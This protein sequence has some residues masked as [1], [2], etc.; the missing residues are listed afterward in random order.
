MPLLPNRR[1]HGRLA[2]ILA[3]C[4][5]LSGCSTLTDLTT[6][7]PKLP[8]LAS[9]TSPSPRPDAS[10][11]PTVKALRKPGGLDR[12]S[13]ER[14]FAAAGVQLV[15]DYWTTDDAS[16]WGPASQG[17]VQL[18][19]QVRGVKDKRFVKVTRVAVVSPPTSLHGTD[20]V[21]L[22]DRGEFVVGAPFSYQSA[23]QLP[24]YLPSTVGVTLTVTVDL[25]LET[26]PGSGTYTRL[27]LQDRL[28]LSLTPLT[29]GNAAPARP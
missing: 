5:G 6:M 9:S 15:L 24:T 18:S 14:V 27:T 8:K 23:F 12:G 19:A 25:E 13:A 4:I 3:T 29:A 7:T 22:D 28:Y 2:L 17:Q 26:A 1:R 10:P 20:V 11:A 21:L 16:R